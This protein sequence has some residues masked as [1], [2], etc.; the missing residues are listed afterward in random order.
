MAESRRIRMPALNP[1]GP[2]KE[3]VQGMEISRVSSTVREG[4]GAAGFPEP[5]AVQTTLDAKEGS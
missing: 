3:M 5:G 4:L 2:A 1:E